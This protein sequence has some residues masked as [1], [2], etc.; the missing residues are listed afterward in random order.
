[1]YNINDLISRIIQT[2]FVIQ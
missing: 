2:D 1:M